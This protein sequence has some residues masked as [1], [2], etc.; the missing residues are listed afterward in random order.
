MLTDAEIVQC[1]EQITDLDSLIDG[2]HDD[3]LGKRLT[4][5]RGVLAGLLGNSLKGDFLEWSGGT[6]PESGH[7][8]SVYIMYAKPSGVTE[9][10]AAD[11]LK[12]WMDDANDVR[13]S[14]S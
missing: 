13:G 9:A 10:F 2:C 1:Q 11:M 6:A 4:K 12:A 3:E 14:W 8:I 5:T 7:Q